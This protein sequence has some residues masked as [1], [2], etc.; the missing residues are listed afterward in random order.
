MRTPWSF[1][2]LCYATIFVLLSTLILFSFFPP[3]SSF[4]GNV[5]EKHGPTTFWLKHEKSAYGYE[6]CTC[7][8]FPSEV[9]LPALTPICNGAGRTVS[10]FCTCAQPIVCPAPWPK[11]Q[12]EVSLSIRLPW[13]HL[14]QPSERLRTVQK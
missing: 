4:R 9:V 13:Q 1:Q 6:L 8:Y 2:R 14:L 10:P 5:S 7:S 12:G 11:M 3:Y